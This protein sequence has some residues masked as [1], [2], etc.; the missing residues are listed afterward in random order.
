MEPSEDQGTTLPPEEPDDSSVAIP[1]VPLEALQPGRASPRLFSWAAAMAVVLVVAL[2]A[3]TLIASHHPSSGST[4]KG[5][6][7]TQEPAGP[8]NIYGLA[9][10]PN[11]EDNGSVFALNGTDGHLRWHYTT[12]DALETAQVVEDGVLYTGST[13]GTVYAF[14]TGNGTLLWSVKLL[15]RSTVWQVVDGVVYATSLDGSQTNQSGRNIAYALDA[16]SG[17]TLWQF[18]NGIS[19]SQVS[20][21]TVYVSSNYDPSQ[22]LG[23]IYALNAQNGTE[24]WQFQGQ[25]AISAW[26]VTGGQVYAM[27]YSSDSTSGFSNSTL[28]TLDASTGGL[29]WSYPKAPSGLI[30]PLGM[31]NGV[32]SLYSQDFSPELA[33]ASDTLS[34]LNAGDGSVRWQVQIP[35]RPPQMSQEA[36]ITSSQELLSDG[37]IYVGNQTDPV[38]AYNASDGAL[39]WSNTQLQNASVETVAQGVVYVVEDATPDAAAL[40]ALDAH[41]GKLLWTYAGK[42]LLIGGVANGVV[43]ATSFDPGPP[44][45]VQAPDNAIYAL[46]ASTGKVRWTYSLGMDLATITVQ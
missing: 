11:T 34:A 25:G 3:T 10:L 17:K 32:I 22:P 7:T 46:D 41:T 19:I 28:Y 9:G 43:Y 14:A 39:L 4:S 8:V 12:P 38:S 23:T 37:V 13:D 2:I 18:P 40:D 6:L 16:R 30:S 33:S 27:E 44:L 24:R 36:I 42:L 5:G 31:E 29:R 1:P 26:R 15:N 20:D 45:T 35:P 21:S